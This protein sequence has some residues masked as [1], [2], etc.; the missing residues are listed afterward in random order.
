[1]GTDDVECPSSLRHVEEAGE[2]NELVGRVASS[3]GMDAEAVFSRFAQI[4]STDGVPPLD[5]AAAATAAAAS[6]FC[7]CCL[8]FLLALLNCPSILAQQVSKYQEQPQLLDPL[9]EGV[10]APLAALLRA[11]AEDPPA[12]DLRR[13]RAIARLLWQLSVVRWAS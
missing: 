5:A 3:G 8:A 4:V 6:P 2:L 9:L 1:M 12:A 13:V 11:A 10:V 7:R